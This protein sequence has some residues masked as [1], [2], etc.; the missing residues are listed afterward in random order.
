[1]AWETRT[2]RIAEGDVERLC[3]LRQGRVTRVNE[4]E[5]GWDLLAEFPPAVETAFADISAPLRRCIIQV[6]STINRRATAKLKL[7]NALKLTT[8]DL[9][10]FT[11]LLTYPTGPEQ[12]E[13]A[14]LQHVWGT[15]MLEALRRSRQAEAQGKALHKQV[16]T[17]TFKRGD[18]HDENVIDALLSAI[19][20]VGPSYAEKKRKLR[21]AMG[22]ETGSVNLTF[23][24]EGPDALRDLDDLV[25]GLRKD[26]PILSAN[27]VRKRFNIPEPPETLG[28]ALLSM[29]EPPTETCALTLR[30]GDEELVWT[31]VV[32]RGLS[33]VPLEARRIRFDAGPFS[34]V[35][36]G[37]RS[38][39]ADWSAPLCEPR[40]LD[41]LLRIARFRSWMDNEK[42]FL[43]IW[44]KQREFPPIGMTFKPDEGHEPAEWQ[45]VLTAIAAIARIVPTERRPPDL[46]VSI[47]EIVRRLD[48]LLLFAS[49][50]SPANH[51]MRVV[52]EKPEDVPIDGVTHILA[53]WSTRLGDHFLVAVVERR[54]TARTAEDGHIDFLT[55][56]GRLLRGTAI[57]AG[58]ATE[59][60]LA[61]EVRWARD[62]MNLSGRRILSFLPV[63]D[64]F[65]DLE[66]TFDDAL[67][68][69]PE[70][71]GHGT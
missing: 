6:K 65:G 59:A 27:L 41:D 1:M 43:S 67:P 40:P 48:S 13:A 57:P 39:K 60:L 4:D 16:L 37:D 49:M 7:S 10:C 61:R 8:D 15:P 28:P 53:P 68:A 26:V 44:T 22:Y 69:A 62:Q 58:D 12:F 9:P 2:D 25:L 11:I 55:C 36:R 30:R 31:G 14:Y 50:C 70:T 24:V 38:I 5:N 45:D 33:L 21:D 23:T 35:V 54:V 52:S 63:K 3:R 18:R 32:H 19:D 20:E 71:S 47:D 42:H 34:V 56:D 51:G 17:L 29:A 66:L 64:G 46:L